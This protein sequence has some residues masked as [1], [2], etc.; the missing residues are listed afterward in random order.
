MEKSTL[1]NVARLL[2][3]VPIAL[4]LLGINQ[5]MVALDLR[6]TLEQGEAATAE[7]LEF[8][9]NDRPDIPFGYVSLKATLS[10]GSEIVQEKMALPYTLLPRVEH[11]LTLDVRVVPGAD[12]QIVITDI[13]QTQ[14]KIAAMQ[15]AICFGVMLMAG[16]GL[17]LWNRMLT[18]IGDPASRSAANPA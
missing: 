1:T 8:V 11:A 6:D 2:W 5:W 14:W 13:A 16:V 3:L 18:S 15:A 7:V 17:F 12:Q 4:L 9:K 10:D